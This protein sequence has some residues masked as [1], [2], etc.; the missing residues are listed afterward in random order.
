[1]DELIESIRAA[2]AAEASPE[3]RAVGATAC[4]T[5]LAALE[6]VPGQ[7]LT[8]TVATTSPIAT[9]VAML[10]GVPPEQLLDLAI[11][12]LRAALP[13][14]VTVAPVHPVRFQIVPMHHNRS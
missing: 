3:N 4:R 7:P 2:V 13:A 8:A 9:A 6:A 14:E 12:R 10:R 5:I 11:A 1:M